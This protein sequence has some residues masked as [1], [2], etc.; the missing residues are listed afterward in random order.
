[1]HVA[2]HLNI[3]LLAHEHDEEVTCLVNL[4]APTP[5]HS[6]SRPG[7]TLVV[8]LDRSGSMSGSPLEGAKDAIGTLVKRLAP[9]DAFGL[10]VFD[11]QAAVI[12]PVRP[13]ADHDLP[14]LRLAVAQI[15]SGGSTDISAG[16]VLALREAKRSLAQTGQRGAT[17]LIVSDGDANAGIQ[18]A[19]QLDDLALQSFREHHITT[20]TLGLGSDYNEVLLAALTH[21]GNGEHVFSPTIDAAAADIAGLV[22]NLLD[23]SVVGATLRITYQPALVSQVLLRNETIAYTEDAT[24]V[25]PLGDLYAAEQRSLLVKFRVPGMENLG[26]TTIADIVV[27]YTTLPALQE[28]AITLPIAVNVVPGDEARGRVPNP[29][30]EVA[31]LLADLAADKKSAGDALRQG[32]TRSAQRTLSGSISKVN[33]KRKDLSSRTDIEPTLTEQLDAAARELL[34]LADDVKNRD[35]QYSSKTMMA[36]YS[37]QSRG[38]TR[39]PRPADTDED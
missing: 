25:V 1:M 2:A 13:M 15:A 37:A 27:E 7:Q 5:T 17:I 28:H 18:D 3:D 12:A 4:T 10:I 33:T 24:I 30:V 14:Q 16:Y 34:A 6:A 26:T 22:G 32:D 36:A 23:K 8:V 20:S 29:A 38:R 39:P 19:Q 21:G 31:E 35:A 9:Q 11:D